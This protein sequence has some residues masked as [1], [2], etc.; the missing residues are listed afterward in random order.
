VFAAHYEYG[1]AT[2]NPSNPFSLSAGAPTDKPA[3]TCRALIQQRF[4][5]FMTR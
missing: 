2:N 4:G 1:A 5:T 3:N